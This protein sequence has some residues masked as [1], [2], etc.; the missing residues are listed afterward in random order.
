VLPLLKHHS[1]DRNWESLFVKA[2]QHRVPEDPQD[3]VLH[4]FQRALLPEPTSRTYYGQEEPL[5]E[6]FDLENSLPG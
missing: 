2:R 5:E 4:I 3:D 1:L 6:L